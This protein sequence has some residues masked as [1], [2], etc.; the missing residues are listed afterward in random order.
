MIPLRFSLAA[1]LAAA[2]LSIPAAAQTD[3]GQCIVAGRLSGGQWAPRLAGVQLLAA[4]G[5]AVTSGSRDRLASVRQVRLSQPALLS[6]CD[7]NAGL[8]QADQEPVQP[9]APVPALAAGRFDVEAVTF[10]KLRSGGELVEL[11]VRTAP[12]RV[13]MLMR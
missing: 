13:V 7:G 6:R 3:A 1:A 12:E 11:R 5:Q 9:K 8:T 4:S 2:F 10:P